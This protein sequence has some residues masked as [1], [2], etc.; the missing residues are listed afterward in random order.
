MDKLSDANFVIFDLFSEACWDE[1]RKLFDTRCEATYEFA[2]EYLAKQ[3]V[4]VWD[5][6]NGHY[7]NGERRLRFYRE[8][9]DDSSTS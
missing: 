7:S 1:E 4:L 2:A 8:V 9:E 3:G 5:A 6:S